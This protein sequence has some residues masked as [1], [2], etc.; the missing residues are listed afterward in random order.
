MIYWESAITLLYKS[1]GPPT[2]LLAWGQSL[3]SGDRVDERQ[4]LRRVLQDWQG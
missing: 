3:V 1:Y 2:F 4:A